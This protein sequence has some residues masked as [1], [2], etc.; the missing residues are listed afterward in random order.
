MEILEYSEA[1]VEKNGDLDFSHTKIIIRR[2]SLHYYAI[3]SNRYHTASE[4]D[5]EALQQVPILSSRIWPAFPSDLTR[6]PEPLPDDCYVKRPCLLY[7]GDS[8][9]A[10]TELATLTF[11]EAKTCEI[12]KKSPH[13]NI[14]QYLGCLVNEHNRTK[15]LCFKRY[16]ETLAQMVGRAHHFDRNLC[17]ES[18]RLGIKHLHGLG[19]IHCDINPHNI[20]VDGDQTEFVI[21]DFDSCTLQGN[22]LGLKAGTKEWTDESFKVAMPENDWY[23]L[24]KIEAYLYPRSET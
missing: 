6:V 22:V 19:I 1:F 12:L 9:E 11:H 20:F 13:P 14:A 8:E 23:G 4:I 16:E 17:L 5:P 24:A 7:Y 2:G 15:G 10:P 21:G 3:S 18:I